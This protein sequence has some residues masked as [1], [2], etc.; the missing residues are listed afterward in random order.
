MHPIKYILILIIDVAERFS[1]QMNKIIKTPLNTAE[2]YYGILF[3][4][5][6]APRTPSHSSQPPVTPQTPSDTH[7]SSWHTICHHTVP[8]WHTIDTQQSPPDTQH[9][10]PDTHSP[11][12]TP[13]IQLFTPYTPSRYLPIPFWHPHPHSITLQPLL[14]SHITLLTPCSPLLTLIHLS[15]L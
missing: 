8:S 11:L 10:P 1:E 3:P 6:V 7:Y 14:S 5:T 15:P 12:L 2:A 13:H 4:L 9:S